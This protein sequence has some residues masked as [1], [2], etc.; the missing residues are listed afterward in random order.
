MALGCGQKSLWVD[1]EGILQDAL[2]KIR[3]PPDSP[4][5]QPIARI[6]L[7]KFPDKLSREVLYEEASRGAKTTQLSV[8]SARKRL[9]SKWR[10]AVA[11][12]A[13]F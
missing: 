6:Y 7:Q 4:R 13:L 10:E 8:D 9:F 5:P 1:F 3:P 12:A 11:E 2:N